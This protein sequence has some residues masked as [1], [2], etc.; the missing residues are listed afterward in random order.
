MSVGS[1]PRDTGNL[2][3]YELDGSELKCLKEE[4]KKVSFKC[5]TFGHASLSHRTLA[6]GDFHG[7]LAVWDLE[8]SA[9]PAW[10][11]LW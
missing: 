2:S 11:T 4:E 8:K 6:T 7:N 1:N 5:A 3:V 9:H 10:T